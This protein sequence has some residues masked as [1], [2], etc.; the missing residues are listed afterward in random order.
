MKKIVITFALLFVLN[1][2]YS[3]AWGKNSKIK[4]TGTIKTETRTTSNY[5]EIEIGGAFQVTL[6]KGTEGKIIITADEAILEK[7]ITKCSSNRLKIKMENGSNYSAKIEISIPVEDISRFSYAGSGNVKSEL[8]VKS[9]NFEVEF[10]GSG[11]VNL[12]VTC[13]NLKVEKTGS[14]GLILSG[15]SNNFDLKCIGSGSSNTKELKTQNTDVSQIGSGD[16]SVYATES[17]NATL[18]GSG[19]INYYGKPA[20]VIKKSNGSG[21]ISAK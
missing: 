12:P 14:G 21:S 8:T 16:V 7:L 18:T 4:L 3:Q 2:G 17:I 9:S 10:S 15:M 20:K 13:Q 11:K 5:N 1:L 19:N 6:V